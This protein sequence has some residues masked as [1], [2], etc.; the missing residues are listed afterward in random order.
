M[1]QPTFDLDVL[2]A[3][4]QTVYATVH[5]PAGVPRG[6]L[7]I[8]HGFKGYKD[9]GMLP[10]VARAAAE[11]GHVAVR[12]NLSHSGM[13]RVM[14]R[15]ERPDLF[16]K[17]TWRKQVTDIL[18]VSDAMRERYD[19]PQVWFGH[20]RGGCAVLLAAGEREPAGVVTAAAVADCIR[21]SPE[22][23]EQWK[24]EGRLVV[25]SSRTGQVLPIE[26]D[27]LAEC[28]ADPVWHDPI[29][30]AG[31]LACPLTI[32]HGIA[33]STVPTADA[34]RLHEA[35][36]DSKLHL[37]ESG[38]HVFN[39]PNPLDEDAAM[40]AETGAVVAEVLAMLTQVSA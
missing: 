33:D 32:V 29:R 3:D 20:S 1:S 34:K 19:L 24:R 38:T 15:F 11:R 7:L 13:T 16:A 27:M 4:G 21:V 17:D 28:E 5:E 30:A 14:E 35:K 39:C 10:G 23:R 37:I 31:G 18:A 9:Y 25:E 26:V 40:P 6:V 2:G 36:P 22:A 12:L 8:V